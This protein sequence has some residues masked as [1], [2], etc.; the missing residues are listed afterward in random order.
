MRQSRDWGRVTPH[1]PVCMIWVETEYRLSVFFFSFFFSFLSL[2]V[3]LGRWGYAIK[4]ARF[5]DQS[6]IITM[7]F[8][9]TFAMFCSASLCFGS[10]AGEPTVCGLIMFGGVVVRCVASRVLGLFCLGV[11]VLWC[12][13][14]C[15]E[16]LGDRLIWLCFFPCWAS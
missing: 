10:A 7:T 11:S 13:H 14:V 16:A 4:G 2:K 5:I 9:T 1:L 15:F 6:S 8:I 3:F 12:M